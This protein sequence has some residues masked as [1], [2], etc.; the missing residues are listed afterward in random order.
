MIALRAV[1]GERESPHT[2]G[3]IEPQFLHVRVARPRQRIDARPP[4]LRPKD[5]QGFDMRE[6]LILNILVQRLELRHEQAM[7]VDAPSHD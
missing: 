6:E 2:A 3:P 4:H 5:L 7:E 1:E